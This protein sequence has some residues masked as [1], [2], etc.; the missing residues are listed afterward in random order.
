[1]DDVLIGARWQSSCI[2]RT[3]AR[4]NGAS[5][6]SFALSVADANSMIPVVDSWSAVVVLSQVYNVLTIR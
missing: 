1:M 6:D 3:D 2:P 5:Q 4:R